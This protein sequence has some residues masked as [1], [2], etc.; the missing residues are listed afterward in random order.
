MRLEDGMKRFVRWLDILLIAGIGLAVL[1]VPVVRSAS[2]QEPT[3]PSPDVDRAL[4]EATGLAIQANRASI[5]GFLINE[6]EIN[7][8]VYSQDGRTALVWLQQRD[9][10]TGDVI[11]REPGLAIAR[12][13][14]GQGVQA[15]DW[16]VTIQSAESFGS[17]LKALPAEL[18]SEEMLERFAAQASA[19]PA[20]A[21]TFT[22][23]K[24]PWSTALNIKI[25]GSVGHF[26]D[27]NSCS[28]ASC[29]Y[30]YDFW[31]PDASNRMFPLLAAKGGVVVA[32]KETCNNGDTN[33][34]NYIVLRDDSTSPATY[35]LYYHIARSSVP[36]H[37]VSGQT[38]V[39]QG[40][41]I[42]N[43]DDTG[44]SSDH[45]L[46]FHV[47]TSPSN[48]AYSWGNSV[49][50]IFSDV[51]F[52]GGEPRTCS[53]TINHPGYGTECSMGKDGKKGGGDDDILTSGN[54]GA[55]P[56]TGQLDSPAPWAV[57]TGSTL[58]VSG[59]ASDNLGITKVQILANYDGTWKVLDN[60]NYANGSFSKTLDLCALGVPDGPMS[61]AVRI[62]DVE[63]NWAARFT[64]QREIFKNAAC[65]SSGSVVT[66]ACT[67]AAGQVG[68]YSEVNF[69]GSCKKLGAGVFNAASLGVLNNKI[70]SIQVSS[71]TCA[72]LYD[73]DGAD[74]LGRT[75]TLSATD[76]NLA[77]NRIGATLASSVEVAPC[78]GQVDEPFL[79]FPGNQVDTD[80]NSR[81]APNP[82]G[83]TSADSLVLAWTGGTGSLGFTSSLTGAQSMSMAQ[84]NTNTWP[85]GTLK[86]G[87]YT[88]TVTAI[89]S[90]SGNTNSTALNFTVGAGSLPASAAVTAP[91]SYSM[92]DGAPGW[93]GTGLW[94]LTSL[95]KPTRGATTAWLFSGGS[96]FSDPT[97]R[98]GDLTSPPITLPASGTMY[99]RFRYYS[100]VE[101]APYLTQRLATPHWDQRRVQISTDNG[102]TFSDLYQLSDDTQ[103]ILWL[104]S[105][106]ISLAA[107]ANKTVRLRFHFDAV[108]P[109]DNA[110]LGW[111]VDDVRLETTPPDACADNNTSPSSAQA[112]T[113]NGA[114]VSGTI[115]PGGDSDYYSFSGTAG[116]PVR[117]DIDAQTL[118]SG[119]PLDPFIALLD[120]NGRDVLAMNDDEDPNNPEPRFRDSIIATVLQRTG[121][122]YVRVRAWDHPGG[123]GGF[124]QYRLTV[125]QTVAARP[126][127]IVMTKPVDP[128]KIP[129]VPFIV[130]AAVQDNIAGGGISRVDFYW[131]SPDWV[132]GSWTKFATDTD[133]SDGWWSIF[134]PTGDT[135]GSAFYILATNNGGGSRGVLVTGLVPDY[136]APTSSMNSLSTPVNST[137]V[138]LTWTA[139]DLQNDIDHFDVQYRFNGGAWT[140]WNQQPPAQAR[141]AWFV[142]D[143][144]TYEFRMRAV[145]MA[146]NQEAFPSSA[147]ARVQLTGACTPDSFDQA[148]DGARASAQEQALNTSVIHRLCQND[149]DF[150]RF[151]AAAGQEVMIFLASKSGGA[152]ARARLTDSAGTTQYLD[153]A[154]ASV[155]TSAV[156]RWTAP[157]D[158][159]YYLEITSIDARVYGTDV[160]YLLYVGAP[161]QLFL[162]VLGK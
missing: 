14:S 137:A 42:G 116:M 22:G 49:R 40:E 114:A 85:V 11:G 119:N 147:Q 95:D 32:Y 59:T 130:E 90:G 160:Q 7:N 45:H 126:D 20:A 62:F 121:T 75:E 100:D 18:A 118:T 70:A 136:T 2:A 108:D 134:N 30:A 61:L 76:Y 64:G 125:S 4:R 66:P 5:L 151:N 129:V 111:A 159:S 103:G 35:Q 26:L 43:V 96:N 21:Q 84:A 67:P 31:N 25:T 131:H 56:P 98:A 156:A 109:L 72:T 86:P 94:K 88:W 33:C 9:P 24:L 140:N 17:E 50:I 37:F 69:G 115:C 146:G 58:A 141:S 39:P 79:T 12:N 29:R 152:A 71:G 105:P 122:Y 83:P 143:P 106:A 117:I 150:V 15:S 82:P 142:G 60:A 63:G 138:N 48:S 102:A 65:G 92:E 107:Y 6:V 93:T 97:F 19:A 158:G 16:K 132:N 110:G 124:H 47:Y 23:Y 157:A 144:G 123:G 113:V 148:G 36:D 10:D 38:Y 77:D 89:G 153:F 101:G 74:P 91:V 1:L 104:D 13:P 154:A 133:G 139:Q 155:G 28:E 51:P 46:H 68:I 53:E 78:T 149:T 44:Y 41:Y 135:T 27:Y 81:L 161:R 99:L 55:N 80:G 145:D 34:T 73:R 8:I 3:P 87:N 127:S 57:V 128:K 54:V 112:V 120:S 162:P 52:N